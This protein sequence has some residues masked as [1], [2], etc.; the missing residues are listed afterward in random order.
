MS[1]V[2]QYVGFFTLIVALWIGGVN[3]EPDVF[4]LGR[5]AA[6]IYMRIVVVIFIFPAVSPPTSHSMN[7]TALVEGSIDAARRVLLFFFAMYGEVHWLKGRME[8]KYT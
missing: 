8:T 7:Y 2:C 3:F 4:N 5:L 1:L 6:S